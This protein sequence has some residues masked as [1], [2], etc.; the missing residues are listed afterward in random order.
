MGVTR[1]W[2]ERECY[3]LSLPDSRSHLL[4]AKLLAKTDL[5]RAMWHYW[6]AHLDGLFF[7]SSMTTLINQLIK[8]DYFD[9]LI[10]LK[11]HRIYSLMV[12]MVGMIKM[13]VGMDDPYIFRMIG[14]LTIGGGNSQSPHNPLLP[15]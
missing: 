1:I 6:R 7:D 5:E 8:I 3:R 12:F 14:E 2:S 9:R 15:P 10:E 4:L 11:R 13:A